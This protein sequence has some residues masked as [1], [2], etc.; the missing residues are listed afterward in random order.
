[1]ARIAHTV[2]TL[3]VLNTAIW[4]PLTVMWLRL[5]ILDSVG[6]KYVHHFLADLNLSGIAN[7]CF[8]CSTATDFVAESKD[9]LGFSLHA[10]D[11]ANIRVASN[12]E[13]APSLSSSSNCR[14]VGIQC[15]CGYWFV[16]A[17]NIQRRERRAKCLFHTCTV[18]ACAVILRR[19]LVGTLDDVCRATKEVRT[20]RF[21]IRVTLT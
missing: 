13:L 2:C 7:Q 14:H 15:V 12:I 16:A 9:E 6:K 8:H 20:E 3:Y 11:R 10:V 5:V 19:V 1:M 21:V 4:Y 18:N 17:V